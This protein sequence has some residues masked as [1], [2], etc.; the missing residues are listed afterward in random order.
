MTV[1]VISLTYAT[2]NTVAKVPSGSANE[3][4]ISI[5]RN[6]LQEI[7]IVFVLISG[8]YAMVL[9][10]WGNLNSKIGHLDPKMGSTAMW[11]QASGN[12]NNNQINYLLHIILSLII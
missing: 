9:T 7:S 3:E 10:Q 8:Y 12:K 5:L 2:Y 6:I 1:M 11:L 4:Q